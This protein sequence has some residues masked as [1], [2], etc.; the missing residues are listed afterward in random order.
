VSATEATEVEATQEPASA[1]ETTLAVPVPEVVG[2]PRTTWL[3]RLADAP[4]SVVDMFVSEASPFGDHVLDTGT[5]EGVVR[6]S[7]RANAYLSLEP[8]LTGWSCDDG[9]MTFA[10]H[11]RAAFAVGGVHVAEGGST[12]ALLKTFTEA[13][14]DAGYRRA[15][16]FPVSAEERAAFDAAGLET[17]MLGSEAFLDRDSW[18]MK[19]KSK[20]DLR[21]MVN[22]GRKRYTLQ[23]VEYTAQRAQVEIAPLHAAWL[24]TKQS[25]H[26]MRLVV[27]SPGFDRPGD[28]RYFVARDGTGTP[29]AFLTLCPGWDGEGWGI[30]VM[31][32]PTEAPAG[33]M[34]VLITD[35]LTTVFDEGARVLSLGAAPMAERNDVTGHDRWFLRKVFRW[36]YGSGLG[37]R[38]FR[39]ESLARYKDKFDPRWEP[40]YM[41]GW[42][43]LN[44]WTLYVGCRM[45]GLFG[46]PRITL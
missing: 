35:V 14:R 31:A 1:K 26:R 33:A 11:M 19:G 38:L 20:A 3:Q 7:P 30:D 25:R 6:R 32:R 46:P 37:N 42:R 4:G 41:G 15:L 21:Q 18:T 44:W 27:G 10:R 24:A 8:E 29:V 2:A 40:V 17:L 34:D 39:F 23:T 16:F 5:L 13:L 45:W 9:V 28:R 12:A 36:L 43:R 22:R